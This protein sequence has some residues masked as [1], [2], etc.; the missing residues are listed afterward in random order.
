MRAI[1]FDPLS[2]I[3]AVNAPHPETDQLTIQFH[4]LNTLPMASN[5][6]SCFSL[7][8]T[9][10]RLYS[11]VVYSKNPDGHRNTTISETMAAIL[12]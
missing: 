7:S 12:D 10:G 8:K 9:V 2:Y 4:M 5:V 3:N 6:M 1:I 11:L